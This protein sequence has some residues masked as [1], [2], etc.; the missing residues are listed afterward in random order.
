MIL[1]ILHYLTSAVKINFTGFFLLFNEFAR[2]IKIT[3]AAGQKGACQSQLGCTPLSPSLDS[4]LLAQPFTG[5]WETPDPGPH[6]QG[7]TANLTVN[8]D[9]GQTM[10]NSERSWKTS[11]GVNSKTLSRNTAEGH[12]QAKAEPMYSLK[13]VNNSIILS[14]H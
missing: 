9:R 8:H 7:L 5:G 6:S 3:S 14:Q 13:L 2:H 4:K 11:K 10:L 1:S 12:L